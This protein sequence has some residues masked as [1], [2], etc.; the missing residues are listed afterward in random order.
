MPVPS[1]P[2]VSCSPGPARPRQLQCELDGEG[3]GT[4]LPPPPVIPTPPLPVPQPL[5]TSCQEAHITR[6]STHLETWHSW[7]PRGTW[8]ADGGALLGDRMVRPSW[9]PRGQHPGAPRRATAHGK[10][11]VAEPRQGPVGC[12]QGL[13]GARLGWTPLRA[14]QSLCRP[15]VSKQLFMSSCRLH[16]G[17]FISELPR[18]GPTTAAMPR[19]GAH[20]AQQPGLSVQGPC[21]PP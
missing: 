18:G 12:G 5:M 1:P 8:R 20:L 19:P 11:T 13:R 21:A 2:W 16:R 14:A 3:W 7:R 9:P 10:E 17:A 6:T 15:W 4:A